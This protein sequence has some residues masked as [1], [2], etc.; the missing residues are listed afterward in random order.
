MED[1]ETTEELDYTEETEES[2]LGS[3]AIGAAVLV[4]VGALGA[5]LGRN[6][7]RLKDAVLDRRA[8]R[9]ERKALKK[10]SKNKEVIIEK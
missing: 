5:Y 8:V 1:I 2:G 10:E 9:K 6:G 7:G 4:G 3:L